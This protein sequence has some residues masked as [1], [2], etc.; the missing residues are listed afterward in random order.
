MIKT[1]KKTMEWEKVRKTE[2]IPQFESWGITSCEIH[3]EGVC[4]NNNALGFAHTKK[5][6]DIKTPEDLREV[7]LACNPCHAIVERH[8][9]EYFGVDML[10]F[11]RGI[12]ERR[13]K[14]QNTYRSL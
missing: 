8:C 9:Q 7:V 10:V 6:R 1:G 13:H 5:R 4:W 12:I 14:N 3:L 11:L 2:L